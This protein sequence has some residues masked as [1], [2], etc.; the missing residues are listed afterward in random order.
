MKICVLSDTHIPVAAPEL[1]P[2]LLRGME[3][4]DL[5][6]HAGDIVELRVLDD[7]RAIAPVEAVRGNMDRADVQQ[8][9]PAKKVIPAQGKRIGLVHGSGAP[10][11]VAN[12]VLREFEDVDIIVFGH[13]HHPLNEERNKVRLFNPGSPT[14]RRFAPY[15]SYGIIEITDDT[16]KAEIVRLG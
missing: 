5:I 3:G 9:L 2:E 8:A 4:A 6:L 15:K 12:R 16:V 13:S 1:P 7:L 11:G 10:W 14:D